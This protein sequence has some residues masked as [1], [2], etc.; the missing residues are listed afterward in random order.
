M[1]VAE[2]RDVLRIL[3]GIGNKIRKF[4]IELL[5]RIFV[6]HTDEQ[7]NKM[8]ADNIGLETML[9]S[10]IDVS[11]SLTR[12][13]V[14]TFYNISINHGVCPIC[15][16]CKTEIRDIHD[17]SWDHSQP[18]SL[19]GPDD[20]F[21]MQP[22]HKCCN[23]FKGNKLDTISVDMYLRH[24]EQ[25]TSTKPPQ[26]E[27]DLGKVDSSSY[28]RRLKRVKLKNTN[29]DDFFP[30]KTRQQNKE[31]YKKHRQHIHANGWGDLN[32]FMN[33]YGK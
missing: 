29:T 19:G 28:V 11:G 21:N 17:F 24:F 32:D 25:I 26:R 12:D 10:L 20:V 1:T 8:S 18:K 4:E 14:K 27:E 2:V 30:S 16:G 13:E 22:M 5:F 9:N 31:L 33:K 23:E 15:A 3:A 7:Y 6:V